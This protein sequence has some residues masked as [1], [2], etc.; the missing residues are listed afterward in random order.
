MGDKLKVFKNGMHFKGLPYKEKLFKI[1][2]GS[3]NFQKSPADISRF[4]KFQYGEAHLN[5]ITYEDFVMYYETKALIRE[6]GPVKYPFKTL[7]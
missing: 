7:L 6:I 5:G 4:E 1:Y 3:K 2:N